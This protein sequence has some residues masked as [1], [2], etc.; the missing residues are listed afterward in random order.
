M[1]DD[2]FRNNLDIRMAQVNR[3]KLAQG[4]RGVFP[5]FQEADKH[6]VCL[7]HVVTPKIVHNLLHQM[8]L[9]CNQFSIKK[10]AAF[11]GI[12]LKHSAA[13]AENRKNR[14]LIKGT[15]RALKAVSHEMLRLCV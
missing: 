9:V 11:K 15:Q 7:V 13:K 14:Y 12:V 10:A 5:A 1:K 8:A 2:V 4:F 6:W 3:Q